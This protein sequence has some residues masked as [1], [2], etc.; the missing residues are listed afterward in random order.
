MGNLNEYI[1]VYERKAEPYEDMPGY[2]MEHDDE[3]GF[4]SWKKDGDILDIGHTC[5]DMRKIHQRIMWRAKGLDCYRVTTRTP[6][7]PA[8][9]LRR[10]HMLG[11]DAHLNLKKSGYLGNGRWYWF[12]EGDVT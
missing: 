1:A 3:Y 9:Y 5:G 10:C 6:R 8:A 12:M 4:F 2:T 11:I 7:N